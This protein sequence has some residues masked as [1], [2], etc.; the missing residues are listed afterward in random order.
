MES[1][2]MTGRGAHE[3]VGGGAPER[4]HPWQVAL[5]LTALAAPVPPGFSFS[6]Y[7]V[8]FW[9]PVAFS[10]TAALIALPLFFH[11]RRST[12]AG[13]AAIVGA[14][15]VPWSVLG[16]LAGMGVFFLSVPLLWL[17]VAADP[18][19]RPVAG[20][21]LAA[22]GAVLAVAMVVVPGFWWQR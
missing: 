6:H 7:T 21:V 3:G 16:S 22:A 12:F 10:L 17:A 11:R 19:R 20:P 1:R 8:G 13:S 2:V 5:V 18:R 14:V 9:Y 4:A 15:L